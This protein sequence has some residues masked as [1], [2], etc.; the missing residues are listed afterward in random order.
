[1]LKRILALTALILLVIVVLQTLTLPSSSESSSAAHQAV[2]VYHSALE[3]NRVTRQ[4]ELEAEIQ[5]YRIAATAVTSLWPVAFLAFLAFGA[6][7]G[8]HVVELAT[9]GHYASQT[10]KYIHSQR[11]TPDTLTY[12]PSN[13]YSPQIHYRN[14]QQ[15]MIEPPANPLQVPGFS[16]LLATGAI[17]ADKP[18]LLGYTDE[19]ALTGSWL[20]LYSSAI[21]G[22]S[23]SG[24]TTTLRFLA[25]QA[26][27]HGA[28]FCLIDPHA[29]A[30]Q[31]SLAGTL[32]P[33][34]PAFLRAPASND[35]EIL[36]TVKY[37][38]SRLEKRIKGQET[39]HS[40]I[41]VAVDEFTSLMRSERLAE[42]LGGLLEAIAQEGRKVGVFAL[43]SG[44]IWT[45]DR[46]GGSTLRD[47]LASAYVHRIKR[48]QAGFLLGMGDRLPDTSD[49][50]PGQ[51]ML[52]RT[53]G[54]LARVTIPL[55][56]EQDILAVAGKLGQ[57]VTAR[58]KPGTSQVRAV[59]AELV[60]TEPATG[61]QPATFT[62]QELAILALQRQGKTRKAIVAEVFGEQ[63]ANGN[64]FILKSREV[65]A[66]IA[67]FV[68]MHL[69]DVA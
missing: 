30:G 41:I 65:D 69:G 54:E 43:L 18:L 32:K 46:A 6:W 20:D 67:K 4:N 2:D 59:E 57:P 12:S 26:A 8:F 1:M 52:L 58:Y 63:A 33:L 61:A 51:A 47:S 11:P 31:E 16:Q 56:T 53:S 19:G 38:Q 35:K 24:K 9:R 36:A 37:A 15:G 49:L 39:D 22:I 64:Q 7:R 3:M 48:R 44:Q 68:Q 60:D 29:D 55:T 40:P 45:A 62:D 5:P 34:E 13:T 23:G 10:A 28:R 66:V 17:G 14:D 27:L 42:P 50:P 21:A 25:G